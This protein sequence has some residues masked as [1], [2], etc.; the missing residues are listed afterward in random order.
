MKTLINTLF[1]LAAIA[2]LVVTAVGLKRWSAS[3]KTSRDALAVLLEKNTALR[4][5]IAGLKS[6]ATTSLPTDPADDA[7]KNAL[8]KKQL[9]EQRAQSREKE[10][11]KAAQRR[12][13]FNATQERMANDREFSFKYYASLRSEVDVQYGPFY[14]LQHLTKEQTDALAEALFQ[15]RLRYE[16]A[17]NEK[18]AGGTDADAK[19]AKAGADA[20]FTAAA[21]NV[22]AE[23]S[24]EQFSLYE[25]QRE[26]WD[27]TGTFGGML[28][29]VDMPLNME[30]AIR[31]ADAIAN[32]NSS[33]Q[34]G[35]EVRMMS[36]NTDWG[37]VNAAAAEFLTPEQ[38]SFL[39]NVDV[40]GMGGALGFSPSQQMDEYLV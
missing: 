29:V 3:T 1:V 5:R 34:I 30:Q 16:K 19:T 35:N 2:A 13:Y 31:M 12:A 23:D 8:H 27:Y 25:R 4:A 40:S 24:Y 26:A 33:Y 32:A 28:S 39:K 21:Q 14:R 18:R 38:L 10:K 22:L 17:N 6:A 7:R 15:R 11:Q 20:E 9:E 36:A 37:A